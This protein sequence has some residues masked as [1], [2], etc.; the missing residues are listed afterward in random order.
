[1]QKISEDAVRWAYRL[2]LDREVES[3]QV[4]AQNLGT[5]STVSELKRDIVNSAEYRTTQ[6][7]P[8][9]DAQSPFFHYASTFDP[10]ETMY[11]HA[12]SGLT[13][14]PGMVV[15][16]LGVVIDPKFF[17]AILSAKGGEIEAIPIPANWHADIAEWGAALRAVDLSSNDFVMIELGCGW[18]C[19]MNNSGVAARAQGRNVKVIGIEADEDHVGFARESLATNG[20]RPDQ[21]E[22]HRGIASF[23]TGVA[24]FPK[25]DIPGSTWGSEPLFD[26]TPEQRDEAIASGHFD[27]VAMVPLADVIGSNPRIDLLHIDIQGGEADLVAQ[28]LALLGERVAYMLIGTHSK[29]IE[30]R[31]YSTLLEAGWLLEMERAAIFDLPE[32]QPR[33]RVDGVQGWRNPALLPL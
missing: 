9:R 12:A 5:F 26:P 10:I 13:A 11:R 17:P 22:L 28:N 16:F 33:I 32:G 14:K 29:Q 31:L 7:A 24:L 18:G 20:F 19:W 4:I 2:L 1:M 25:Q 6:G 27:E 8:A 21:I 23:K 30:G 15:N 3:D